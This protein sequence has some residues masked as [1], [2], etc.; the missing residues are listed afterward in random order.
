MS[1]KV[2]VRRRME[3]RMGHRHRTPCWVQHM[4][5]FDE[6]ESTKMRKMMGAQSAMGV[7]TH[8]YKSLAHMRILESC[9]F[10]DHNHSQMHLGK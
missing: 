3:C 8:Y 10:L 1:H 6:Q 5:G 7:D 9:Y 2:R 4:I